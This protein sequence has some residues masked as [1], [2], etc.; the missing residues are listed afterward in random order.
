[1]KKYPDLSGKKILVTGATDGIGKELSRM[2]AHSGATLIFHF[3]NPEHLANTL[4]EIKSETGNSDIQTV[5]ADFT[6]GSEV[7]SIAN[8]VKQKVE[9]LDVLVNN[10]GLYPQGKTITVDG[11][12][13]TLQVNYAQNCS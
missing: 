4:K 6:W 10:A 8:D 9:H 13:Q 5:I 2:F 3:P 12:E 1:M 11:F 7:K